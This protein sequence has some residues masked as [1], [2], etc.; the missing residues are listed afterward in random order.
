MTLQ[1]FWLVDKKVYPYLMA[2]FNLSGSPITAAP[3][4][5]MA[6]SLNNPAGSSDTPNRNNHAFSTATLLGVG[7][8]IGIPAILTCMAVIVL[9]HFRKRRNQEAGTSMD[10]Y[11]ATKPNWLQSTIAPN[12]SASAPV[13]SSGSSRARLQEMDAQRCWE[14]HGE[15]DAD[16][17]WELHGGVQRHSQA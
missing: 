2:P 14:L 12:P 16:G 9:Y 10:G 8:G 6:V 5:N 17:R 1:G 15:T 4:N 11:L 3:S 7:F 13:K